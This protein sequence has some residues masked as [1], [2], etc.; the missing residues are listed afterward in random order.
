[1][2][3][4][5]EYGEDAEQKAYQKKLESDDT[6]GANIRELIVCQKAQLQ[7]SHKTIRNLRDG[8]KANKSS[9]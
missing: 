3:E 1:M 2:L 9:L 7:N 4:R 6:Q 8:A 5:C